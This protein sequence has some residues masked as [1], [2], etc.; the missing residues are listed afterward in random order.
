MTNCSVNS[1]PAVGK[2]SMSVSWQLFTV[3]METEEASLVDECIVRNRAS[4]NLC[5]QVT[6]VVLN[7]HHTGLRTR[8]EQVVNAPFI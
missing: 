1:N 8:R 6:I 4:L 2:D 3:T 5:C 7:F